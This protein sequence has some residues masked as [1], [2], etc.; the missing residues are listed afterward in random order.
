VNIFGQKQI[1]HP[2]DGNPFAYI[3][4]KAPHHL[5]VPVKDLKQI[6]NRILLLFFLLQQRQKIIIMISACMADENCPAL[7]NMCRTNLVS[8]TAVLTEYD[9]SIP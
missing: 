8:I 4:D 9:H 7:D 1:R 3:I 5:R 2:S 6:I